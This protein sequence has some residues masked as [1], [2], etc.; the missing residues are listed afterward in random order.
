[1]NINIE[2]LGLRRDSKVAICIHDEKHI[3]DMYSFIQ[4][5]NRINIRPVVIALEYSVG[6]KLRELK[7]S[8]ALFTLECLE[9]YIGNG[10]YDGIDSKAIYYASEWFKD[11]EQDYSEF[12]GFS[13][14]SLMQ[15]DMSYCFSEIIA[16]TKNISKIV[17]VKSPDILVF[18]NNRV[19]HKGLTLQVGEDWHSEVAASLFDDSIR[20]FC[21]TVESPRRRSN[22]KALN[23]IINHCALMLTLA[24][25]RI[26]YLAQSLMQYKRNIA[27]SFLS[28][29][30]ED[31]INSFLA[32][33][34]NRIV[35]LTTKPSRYDYKYLFRFSFNSLILP[36]KFKADKDARKFF[37]QI[38]NKFEEEKK[39][40]FIIDGFNLWPV[41]KS[42]MQYIFWDMFPCIVNELKSI[43]RGYK[44]LCLTHI[45]VATD[46]TF[47]EKK[48]ISISNQ[49]GI[50]S[51]VLQHGDI[52]HAI[53]YLPST[54]SK[55]AAWG[56]DSRDWFLE[57]NVEPEKVQSLG[58]QKLDRVEKMAANKQQIKDTVYELLDIG[59]DKKLITFTSIGFGKQIKFSNVHILLK[60]NL[61]YIE[62]LRSAVS[63][64]DSVALVIKL[65]QADPYLEFVKSYLAK[66]SNGKSEVIVS[67]DIDVHKLICASELVVT[68]YSTTGIEAMAAEVPVL[69]L[70]FRGK[71]FSSGSGYL[72]KGACVGAH[73]SEEVLPAIKR[74]MY[75]KDYREGVLARIRRYFDYSVTKYEIEKLLE[76]IYENR[77]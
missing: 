21:I 47:R 3:L 17:E 70:N 23:N 1:M 5:L 44:G 53:G 16:C 30:E 19:E 74:I 64:I 7:E 11:D 73:K 8:P 58:S 71:R 18:L 15:R 33:K 32:D 76:F 25:E 52:G 77:E 65:H 34:S 61:K 38:W 2:K 55:I 12:N 39:N 72:E 60:E 29:N 43:E 66:R 50:P 46:T 20:T 48:L 9:D 68:N 42:R 63:K 36:V 41:I 67:K 69:C 26:K 35:F 27:I 6:Y 13:I 40:C 28:R 4:K 22:K 62:S 31:L 14:G 57:N 56:R 59:R 10:F 45:V 49:M 51:T 54:A 75:D 37:E 24:I